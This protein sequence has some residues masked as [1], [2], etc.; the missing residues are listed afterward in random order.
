MSTASLST[1]FGSD[2]PSVLADVVLPSG[3]TIRARIGAE[4]IVTGKD[5]DGNKYVLFVNNAHKAFDFM[6]LPG[7]G[8]YKLSSDV[9]LPNDLKELAKHRLRFKGGLLD[10]DYTEI[11]DLNAAAILDETGVAKDKNV[12]WKYSYYRLFKTT[13]TGTIVT[14]DLDY[15]NDNHEMALEQAVTDEDGYTCYLK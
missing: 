14:D 12:E 5:A 10:T 6:E 3:E 15:F 4:V 1:T 11:V 13:Y 8:L 9:S 7:G 2:T